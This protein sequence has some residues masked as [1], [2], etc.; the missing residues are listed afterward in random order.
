MFNKRGAE[1]NEQNKNDTEINLMLVTY[2]KLDVEYADFIFED[3]KLYESESF[4]KVK[5][6]QYF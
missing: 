1:L 5:G 4:M 3:N 2:S 6:Q